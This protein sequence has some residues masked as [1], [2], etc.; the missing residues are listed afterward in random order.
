MLL[1]SKSKRA[2]LSCWKNHQR[3][4]SIMEF[5]PLSYC[6]MLHAKLPLS[7]VAS[8]ALCSESIRPSEL[9]W[10]VLT[11]TLKTEKFLAL[12]EKGS[13]WL[14]VLLLLHHSTSYLSDDSY[15]QRIAIFLDL[16]VATLLTP[17]W[18]H[19]SAQHALSPMNFPWDGIFG[20]Q[21]LCQ[22]LS[23]FMSWRYLWRR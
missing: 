6:T 4:S 9:A 15:F 2:F 18:N 16:A 3:F 5:Y 1:H 12:T 22:G 23:T 11:Y 20:T 10:I 21:L 19:G 14:L 13:T 7:S 17:S 8:L